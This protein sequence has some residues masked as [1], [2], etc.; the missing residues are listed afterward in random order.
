MRKIN[1]RQKLFCEEYMIDA[2]ATKAAIR[3]GYSEKYAGTN[4]DKL[5][6]NTNLVAYLNKLMD[7]RSERTEI[8]ADAVLTDLRELA[9]MCMGRIPTPKSIAFEG[10]IIETEAKEV[11]AA[12]ANK[13]LELLGKHFRL[14]ADV[15]VYENSLKDMSDAE[16]LTYEAE[17]NQRLAKLDESKKH[18]ATR[19]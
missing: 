7:A 6:K 4:A 19:H 13:S 12:A 11:N 16:L 1:A 5:L 8:T 2:N 15:H 9:D 17:V 10:E 14:F 3:A 18:I